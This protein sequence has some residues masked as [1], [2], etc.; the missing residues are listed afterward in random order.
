MLILYMS[1]RFC[2]VYVKCVKLNSRIKIA[3]EI[4]NVY[5]GVDR[6]LTLIEQSNIA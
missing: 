1:L 2:N 3:I 5:L 4:K 6:S